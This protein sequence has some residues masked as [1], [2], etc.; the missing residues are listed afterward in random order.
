MNL[1]DIHPDPSSAPYR[2]FA[3]ERVPELVWERYRAEPEELGKRERALATHPKYAFWY[4]QS[5]LSKPF[6][7]GEPAIAGDAQCAYWYAAFVLRG[8]FPAGEVAIAKD[9]TYAYLYPRLVL[10]LSGWRAELWPEKSRL[11][12][13]L[14]W[15]LKYALVLP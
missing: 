11:G 8:P 3:F 12:R 7:A 13:G 14:W 9:A 10:G 2:E 1:Y 6:P 15:Y 4:A 5:I